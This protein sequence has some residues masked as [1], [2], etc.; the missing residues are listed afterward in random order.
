MGCRGERASQPGEGHRGRGQGRGQ[1]QGQ[2]G[3]GPGPGGRAGAGASLAWERERRRAA[4]HRADLLVGPLRLVNEQLLPE[5]LRELLEGDDAVAV[6]VDLPEEAVPHARTVA[7]LLVHREE[8][9]ARPVAARDDAESHPLC[10]LDHRRLARARHL[11]QG[12]GQGQGK[13]QNWGQG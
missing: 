13:G 10:E 5:G 9:A 1:G 4:A 8:G 7:V 3:L 6:R 11:G 12:Q 2:E